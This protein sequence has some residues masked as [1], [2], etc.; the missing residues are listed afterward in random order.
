M[1]T[2]GFLVAAYDRV[3]IGDPSGVEMFKKHRIFGVEQQANV[4]ALAIVNMI[5]RGDGKNN[6]VNGDCLSLNLQRKIR[7]GELSAE[8]QENEPD[9][10]PVNKVLMNP[11]FAL[12][13]SDEQEFT[14]IE[15]ALEQMVE[16]GLLLCVIPVSVM[17]SAKKDE[18]SWRKRLLE[19][20]TLLSV[21]SFPNDL[22]YPQA[23]VE[24]VIIIVEKGIPH[25]NKTKTLFSRIVDDGFIKLKK[26]RLPHGKTSQ[27][28][29]L[30]PLIKS[31]IHGDEIEEIPGYLQSKIIDL[32]DKHLE[33]IPQNYLDNAP[34]DQLQL[35]NDMSNLYS[36]LVF[37]QI[38]RGLNK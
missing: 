33:L 19:D 14:F 36:E 25:G 7:N 2:G 20:N 29:E 6:I 4:A 31:F 28:D 12:K 13:R 24:S 1:R 22:F 16:G 3:R 23:S 32:N 37:Q 38:R 17:Y 18:L 9:R 26:R 30:S 11:P 8:Y 27:L 15:H 21:I 34:L 10:P 5:F 35:K